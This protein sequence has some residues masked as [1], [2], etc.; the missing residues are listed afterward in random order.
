MNIEKER[1]YRT[2]HYSDI[3]TRFLSFFGIFS[4]F[5]SG[6]HCGDIS[7]LR[8]SRFHKL[9]FENIFEKSKID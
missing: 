9:I 2:W 3:V 5:F 6:L 8:E 1:K 7:I 4:L